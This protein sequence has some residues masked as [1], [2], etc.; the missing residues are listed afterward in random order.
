MTGFLKGKNMKNLN[1]TLLGSLLCLTQLATIAQTPPYLSITNDSSTSAQIGWT[2]EVGI[3]YRVLATE[4]LNSPITWTPKWDAFSPDANVTV[5][6]PT[7][8]MPQEFIRVLIPTNSGVEIFAPTNSQTVS[9]IITI[10]VG[11]QIGSELMGV[12]LYLDNALVGFIDSGSLAF[13]LDTTHYT[14]GVHSLQ[15]GALDGANGET[16]SAA[17]SLDFENSVRWLDAESLFQSFVPIDVASDIFPAD[18]SV[19]VEDTNGVTVRTFSGSTSDGIIQT[20]WDGYDNN[21]V[22]APDQSGYTIT[23]VVTSTGSSAMMASSAVASSSQSQ[24]IA[25]QNRYGVTEYETEAAAPN[26]MVE[27]AKMLTHYEKLTK[28]EKA[29]YPPLPPAPAKNFKPTLKKKISAREM[30]LAQRQSSSGGGIIMAGANSSSSS[31]SG[32]AHAVVWREAAWNSGQIVLCRQKILGF[33][34]LIYNGVIATL[35]ENIQIWVEAADTGNRSV[36]NNSVLLMEHNGDFNSVKNALA[37]SSPNTRA[38]YFFGH[39][40]PHGNAIG[41]EEGTPNDGIIAKD[42]GTLLGNSSSS[43]RHRKPTV[44]TT[45]PFSFVFLDGCRT[46]VGSFPDAFGI[47]RIVPG[48]SY[49]NNNKHKRAF[50]GWG[51]IVTDSI[52]NNDFIDWSQ[53][54]WQSWVENPDTY[55]KDA[56]DYANGNYPDVQSQAPILPVG[57]QLLKWND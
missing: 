41:F 19:F 32:S 31:S 45:K 8:N 36:L 4:S 13:E 25:K 15:A 9:D 11:A 23:V 39:G 3:S 49:L 29:I 47:P 38:F 35:F 14:N 17:I 54:F 43:A 57:S 37:A 28:A 16:L 56:I 53:A 26:P 22:Y 33:T 20:N 46:G 5:A 1:A 21:A 10:G 12:N 18:W 50:M 2:N 27:Y 34:G 42:L 48:S 44:T 6:I 40:S 7:A 55:L 51:G 52:L 30:W 24:I